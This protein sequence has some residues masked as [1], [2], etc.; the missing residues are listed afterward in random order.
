M[1]YSSTIPA[2]VIPHVRA[3]SLAEH[4]DA[5]AELVEKQSKVFVPRHW[6]ALAPVAERWKAHGALL[7]LIGLPGEEFTRPFEMVISNDRDDSWAVREAL[8]RFQRD[9][10]D[11][12]RAEIE[13]F[14]RDAGI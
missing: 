2:N 6:Q 14:R 1:P 4:T 3:G 5:G 8:D 13:A 9:H 7:E 10:S 12:G 11:V